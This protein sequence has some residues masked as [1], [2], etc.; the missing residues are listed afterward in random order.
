MQGG[1]PA[2]A[3]GHGRMDDIEEAGEQ[4]EGGQARRTATTTREEGTST[5]SPAALAAAMPAAAAPQAIPRPWTAAPA[6]ASSAAAVHAPSTETT[7]DRTRQDAAVDPPLSWLRGPLSPWDSAR[8]TAR[9]WL[10]QILDRGTTA[11]SLMTELARLDAT[12]A[13]DTDR[14]VL[15]ARAHTL[16]RHLFPPP[17]G[18]TSAHGASASSAGYDDLD[19]EAKEWTQMMME[20]QTEQQMR[21]HLDDLWGIESVAHGYEQRLAR[22]RIRAIRLA[23]MGVSTAWP[24]PVRL[25]PASYY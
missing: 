7:T 3:T 5:A 6:A 1:A 13:T 23:L 9:S 4:M 21:D 25:A 15:L 8:T 24:A 2:G 20:D 22:A 10:T 19:H 18:E 16:H 11:V 17:D 12:L 14:L